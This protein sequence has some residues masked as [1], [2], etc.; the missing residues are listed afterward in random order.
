MKEQEIEKNID[1]IEVTLFKYC[2]EVGH[3]YE[4]R[5]MGKKTALSRKL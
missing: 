2:L 5:Q 3:S 4:I 1:G